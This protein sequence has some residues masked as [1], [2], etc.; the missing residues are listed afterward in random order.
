MQIPI[1]LNSYILGLYSWNSFWVWYYAVKFTFS[2]FMTVVVVVAGKITQGYH[3]CP[4]NLRCLQIC[5]GIMGWWNL[6]SLFCKFDNWMDRGVRVLWNCESVYSFVDLSKFYFI[7]GLMKLCIMAFMQI[8][9]FETF[10][11]SLCYL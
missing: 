2:I 10:S 8:S 9:L 6:R 5:R 4:W 7:P 3:I 11:F 1:C